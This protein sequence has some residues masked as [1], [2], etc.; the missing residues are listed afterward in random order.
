MSLSL[1]L[2]LSL[3]YSA[4]YDLIGPFDVPVLPIL[5]QILAT[6]EAKD[7]E[8]GDAKSGGGEFVKIGPA[9]GQQEKNR[10]EMFDD[11]GAN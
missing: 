3:L 1:T 11:I 10:K 7:E 8:T 4:K 5:P 2:S 9:A 6:C